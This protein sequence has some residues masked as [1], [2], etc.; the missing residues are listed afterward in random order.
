[1]AANCN[2]WPLSREG[3]LSCRICCDTGPRFLRSHNLFKPITTNN[4][5]NDMNYPRSGIK[6]NFSDS[7]LIVYVCYCGVFL[8]HP[9]K[10]IYVHL[11]VSYISICH[12]T[13]LT[14][15]QLMFTYSCLFM[16]TVCQHNYAA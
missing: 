1:M 16:L 10:M 5:N 3:S 13:M 6:K 4:G 15:H 9:S 8:P 2:L 14:C 7:L 12:I 11:P